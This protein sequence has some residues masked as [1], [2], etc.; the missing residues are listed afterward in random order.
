MES[1]LVA[2][3]DEPA[4]RI[5]WGT[6]SSPDNPLTQPCKCSGSLRHVHRECNSQWLR[7]SKRAHCEVSVSASP[8]CHAMQPA[9]S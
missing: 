8:D 9:H 6:D 7:T 1:S 4:C 2:S 3:E 5:C